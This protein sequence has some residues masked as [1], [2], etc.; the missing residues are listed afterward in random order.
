MQ[1]TSS[2]PLLPPIAT[3]KADFPQKSCLLYPQ[4]RTCAVQGVMSALGQ[5]GH[6]VG[7]HLPPPTGFLNLSYSLA[8]LLRRVVSSFFM[9]SGV[10]FGRSIV[11][12][13]LLSLPVNL[14][15]T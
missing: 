5:S 11:S 4:E 2:C 14:N 10:S 13:S 7:S 1:R 8:L 6:G 12:V 9:S 15:G 3:A